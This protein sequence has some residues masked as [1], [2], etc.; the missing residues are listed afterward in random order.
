MKIIFNRPATR[1]YNWLVIKEPTTPWYTIHELEEGRRYLSCRLGS[2]MDLVI[3]TT[4]ISEESVEQ[5]VKVLKKKT[6]RLSGTSLAKGGMVP[7]S[8]AD[9]SP[10]KGSIDPYTNTG[11]VEA[12]STQKHLPLGGER[13]GV[14][15]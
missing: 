5:H 3:L 11:S 1:L 4:P 7:L 12:K 2:G 6:L 15:I 14:T 10:I 8:P 9:S 13:E